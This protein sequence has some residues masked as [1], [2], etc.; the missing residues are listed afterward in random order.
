MPMQARCEASETEVQ[1][2]QQRLHAASSDRTAELDHVQQLNRSLKAEIAVLQSR[3]S[4]F[5]DGDHHPQLQSGGLGSGSGGGH[6]ESLGSRMLPDQMLSLTQSQPQ[7]HG[8]EELPFATA[9]RL[10]PIPE[11]DGTQSGQT[12][13]QGDEALHEGGLQLVPELQSQVRALAAS[14]HDETREA[15]ALHLAVE[16]F[17]NEVGVLTP[18]MCA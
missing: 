15:D 11:G 16:R 1:H 13:M 7:L 2:L 12:S 8:E 18:P 9:H 4:G 14:L 3:L 6:L 5:G 10:A 17:R